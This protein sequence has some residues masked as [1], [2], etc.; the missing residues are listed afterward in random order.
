M[1]GRGVL[2]SPLKSG[3]LYKEVIAGKKAARRRKSKPLWR[4]K[5]QN[6]LLATLR[7]AKAAPLF[8]A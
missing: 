7:R 8:S 2:R 4:W 6:T 1:S 5:K 3:G